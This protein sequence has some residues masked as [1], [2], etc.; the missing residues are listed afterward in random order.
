[1]LRTTPDADRSD[2]APQLQLAEERLDLRIRIKEMEDLSIM[3]SSAL[4]A[5]TPP[6][7]KE[8]E[9]LL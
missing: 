9:I 8:A 3:H 4:E 7:Y 6:V 2:S 1:M 5:D